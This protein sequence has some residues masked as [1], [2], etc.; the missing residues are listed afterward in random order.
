MIKVRYM[1]PLETLHNNLCFKNLNNFL[2]RMINDRPTSNEC[3]AKCL[4]DNRI[5]IDNKSDKLESNISR[6][7]D[8][9]DTNSVFLN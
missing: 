2:T 1:R 8:F 6:K 7:L 5:E 3:V 4:L 9:E